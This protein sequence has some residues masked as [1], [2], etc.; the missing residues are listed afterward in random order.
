MGAYL[1]ISL[2]RLAI[3]NSSWVIISKTIITQAIRSHLST[4]I[5]A[6]TILTRSCIIYKRIFTLT[7]Y[8]TPSKSLRLCISITSNA[9]ILRRTITSFASIMALLATIRS[10]WCVF[11]VTIFTQTR[12]CSISLMKIIPWK[13]LSASIRISRLAC[14][15]MIS[16]FSTNYRL[17]A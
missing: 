7:L 17:C 2:T 13:A 16:A 5:W 4:I 3:H 10:T 11:I 9:I 1:T 15:T 8:Y 14:V 12:T 6:Y